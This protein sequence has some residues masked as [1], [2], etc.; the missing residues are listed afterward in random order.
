[1]R[2]QALERARIALLKWEP[3]HRVPSYLQR[4]KPATTN[5]SAEPVAPQVPAA[6]IAPRAVP[7]PLADIPFTVVKRRG[8]PPKS[9]ASDQDE[10]T[11]QQTNELVDTALNITQAPQPEPIT[12]T[13]MLIQGPIASIT[14]EP[15][16]TRSSR[17][18]GNLAPMMSDPER[19][20]R[21][22]TTTSN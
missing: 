13:P 4:V 21:T 1:V 10:A 22:V 14:P 12:I 11:S 15:T 18:G 3:F 17:R 7:T 5:T 16:S 6:P 20:L 19:P 2:K 8:R 9:K